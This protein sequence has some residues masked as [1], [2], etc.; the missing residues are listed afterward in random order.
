MPWWGWITIGALFLAAE[1]TFVDLAFYLVFL[2]ASAFVV[3]LIGLAGPPAAYWPEWFQ[4]IVFAFLSIASLVFFR[5]RLYAKLH[6]PA[7]AKISEGV[8]GAL[9]TATDD[10]AAGARGSVTLRGATWTAQNTGSQA[11]PT[12]SPCRVLSADGLVL[13]IRIEGG[14][15]GAAD[16][17]DKH[18]NDGGA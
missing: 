12:G 11:I 6:P 13:K 17:R 3:G 10:I 2:G 8:N 16:D 14:A 4:W 5:Q 1:M 9:A 7:D 18:P 15:N